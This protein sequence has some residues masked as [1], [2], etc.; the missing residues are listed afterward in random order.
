M[1]EEG[2]E[3]RKITAFRLTRRREGRIKEKKRSDGNPRN[4]TGIRVNP[5]RGRKR[6]KRGKP[7]SFNACVRLKEKKKKTAVLEYM[8]C[9]RSRG[10]PPKQGRKREKEKRMDDLHSEW[11]PPNRKKTEKKERQPVLLASEGKRTGVSIRPS[12]RKKKK[13]VIS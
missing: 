2:G 3:K 11:T 13:K 7:G 12:H 9:I 10:P 8:G 6:G 4:F 5:G 1:K